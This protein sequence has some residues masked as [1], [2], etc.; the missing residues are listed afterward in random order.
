L[1]EFKKLKNTI[2]G[3][4]KWVVHMVTN[5][6]SKVEKIFYLQHKCTN[7]LSRYAMKI[8]LRDI[9]VLAMFS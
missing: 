5:L 2:G 6:I 3:M 9:D 8:V 1:W 7:K 4:S